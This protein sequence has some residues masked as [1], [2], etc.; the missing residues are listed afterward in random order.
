ML[1]SDSND[2]SNSNKPTGKTVPAHSI[3]AILGLKYQAEKNNDEKEFEEEFCEVRQRKKEQNICFYEEDGGKRLKDREQASDVLLPADDWL[4]K[5]QQPQHDSSYDR[6]LRKKH[7]RNR[8]TFTTYQLHELERA[9]ERSHYPDVYSREELALKVNL[10]EVRVQVW[11]QN[12]R[13]KWRRQEKLE[14]QNALRGLGHV[15]SSLLNSS[16]RSQSPIGHSSSGNVTSLNPCVT[17]MSSVGGHLGSNAPLLFDP[18]LTPSLL[19]LRL[20]GLPGFQLHT[21]Y[22]SYLTP[23]NL[24]SGQVSSAESP[25]SKTKTSPLN[26]S[27]DSEDQLNEEHSSRSACDPRSSSIAALRHKAK[28]HL[29]VLSKRQVT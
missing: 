22:P 4:Q 7:R 28:E 11:F 8:T 25:N 13:A 19:G 27:V 15:S 29:Q 21:V 3:D 12:R 16:S 26:L 23:A 14:S 1:C 18:W 6:G 20:P 10:P 17:S 2:S 24:T 9:F 5:P